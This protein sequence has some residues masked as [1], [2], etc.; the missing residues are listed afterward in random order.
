MNYLPIL[1]SSFLFIF[2]F[3]ALT[4]GAFSLLKTKLKWQP[5]TLAGVG[6]VSIVI[7][8]VRWAEI[9]EFWELVR[10]AVL[11]VGG[12]AIALGFL[13]ICTLLIMTRSK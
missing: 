5:L 11:I 3:G 4:L 12:G 13:G 6:I 7:L 2:G 9:P 1:E 10:M 8:F